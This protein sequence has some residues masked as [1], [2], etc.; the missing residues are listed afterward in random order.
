MLSRLAAMTTTNMRAPNRN[1]IFPHQYETTRG[2]L[3]AED[4]EK[5]RGHAGAERI[6]DE[7]G[8][9]RLQQDHRDEPVVGDTNGLE[10][11]ELFQVLDRE[12]VESLPGDDQ[13]DDERNGNRDAEVHRDAGIGEVVSDAVPTELFA[14]AGFEAVVSV[15]RRANSAGVTPV[16]G[17]AST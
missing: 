10:R 7:T 8:G 1:D 11:A 9:E 6:A 4:F 14:G 13:T 5:G 3:M 12:Q 17:R 15:I 2:D 16:C